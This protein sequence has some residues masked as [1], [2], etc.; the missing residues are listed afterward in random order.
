MLHEDRYECLI[1]LC[2]IIED[3]KPTSLS[4]RI[5]HLLDRER[6]LLLQR[7]MFDQDDEVRDRA[8]FYY[9][10]LNQNEKGLYS[11]Y[12]LNRE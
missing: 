1:H 4:T 6:P 12:I 5:L 3:W 10:L 8:T 2:E 9:Q 7:T 11:A